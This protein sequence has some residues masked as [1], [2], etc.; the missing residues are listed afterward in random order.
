[1]IFIYPD[2]LFINVLNRLKMVGLGQK[3]NPFSRFYFKIDKFLSLNTSK[4]TMIPLMLCLN[5]KKKRFEAT[6]H[7]LILRI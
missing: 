6:A 4:K 5:S 2:I 3:K 1:M 7:S